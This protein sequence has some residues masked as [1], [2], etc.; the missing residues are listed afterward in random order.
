MKTMARTVGW[1]ATACA[2]LAVGCYDVAE[3]DEFP[4]WPGD[5]PQDTDADWDTGEPDTGEPDT[6]EPDTGEPDSDSVDTESDLDTDEPDTGEPDT[7]EEDT[8]TDECIEVDPGVAAVAASAS[9][10]EGELSSWNEPLLG[11]VALRIIGIY[12]AGGTDSDPGDC[13]VELNLDHDLVLVLSAYDPVHWHVTNSGSGEI[14]EIIVNSYDPQEI[15]APEGVPVTLTG[16][17]YDSDFW[18]SAYSFDDYDAH[19]VTEEAEAL[20]GLELTS[21]HGCYE[22]YQFTLEEGCD[23]PAE[24]PWPD[25]TEEGEVMGPPDLAAL[26]DACE[27]VTG[28]SYFC[29]SIT[30]D[31]EVVVLGLD[32]GDVCTVVPEVLEDPSYI[33]SIAWLD[34]WIYACPGPFHKLHRVDVTDGTVEEAFVWC[35][36]VGAWDDGLLTN[37]PGGLG[38]EANDSMWYYPTFLDAGCQSPTELSFG[39][40]NHRFTVDGDAVYSAWHS[41]DHVDV[42]SLPWGGDLGSIP[43]EGFDNWVNGMSVIDGELLVIYCSNEARAVVFDLDGNYLWQAPTVSG[44]HGLACV[45]GG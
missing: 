36:S 19:V 3:Y 25:C 13:D 5:L 42:Q 33:H 35:E 21:F 17:W 27:E 45:A 11:D 30:A 4:S 1:L 24:S 7:G 40:E 20:T 9:C 44:L 2:A 16:Y 8:D 31:G 43:L 6:E 41:T 32:T 39:C 37:L 28:E 23:G 10:G 14:V 15:T 12:H 26:G 22:G 29:A 18:G 38:P 34:R